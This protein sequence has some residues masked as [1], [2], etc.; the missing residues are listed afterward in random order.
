MHILLISLRYA[1][2][3][4]VI[5]ASGKKGGWSVLRWPMSAFMSSVALDSQNSLVRA[6]I[7][8]DADLSS[9]QLLGASIIVGYGTDPDEML[10]NARYR[11]IFTAPR[12]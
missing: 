7:L 6:Q 9:P 5:G 4:G 11:T 3:A 10:R 2:P 8:Q 12:P 1:R